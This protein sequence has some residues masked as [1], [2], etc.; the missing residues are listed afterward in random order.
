MVTWIICK[1]FSCSL[2]SG[3]MYSVSF[4]SKENCVFTRFWEASM[5]KSD[6]SLSFKVFVILSY[7][8]IIPSHL[9]QKSFWYCLIFILLLSDI[10]IAPVEVLL[11]VGLLCWTL[12]WSELC[13]YNKHFKQSS[14]IEMFC[15]QRRHVEQ[16]IYLGLDV[17][18]NL[19]ITSTITQTCNL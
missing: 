16:I 3:N 17:P 15:C 11:F 14:V 5:C 13:T 18:I 10:T 9:V 7:L 1:F 6:S 8:V 2:S 4:Q 12:D 19:T